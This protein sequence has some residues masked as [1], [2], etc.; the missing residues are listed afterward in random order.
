MPKKILIVDDEPTTNKMVEFLLRSK[1]Y[2]VI[3]ATDA[4]KGLEEERE[5]EP[6]L[7]VLDVV[8][9]NVDGLTFLR[10][11]KARRGMQMPKVIVL[12]VKA[13]MEEIFRV[14]GVEDF[15][16][17]PLDSDKFAKRIEDCLA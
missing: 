7:I 6:D 13:E 17:K 8:M 15:F 11:L 10:E 5:K 1:G 16:T 2:D 14:E 12:T 9:P 4:A 3:F